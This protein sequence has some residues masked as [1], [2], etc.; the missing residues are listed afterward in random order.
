MKD[1]ERR[2]F[3][4]PPLLIQGYWFESVLLIAAGVMLLLGWQLKV[5]GLNLTQ[6]WLLGTMGG[7]GLLVLVGT[8]AHHQYQRHQQQRTLHDLQ[9]KWQTAYPDISLPP[10]PPDSGRALHTLLDQW[11]PTTKYP[12]CPPPK[13]DANSPISNLAE[14]LL[15]ESQDYLERI[16]AEK[17][18]SLDQM[19]AG[20]AH[21]INN[22]INFILGNLPLAQSYIQ[23][24]LILI[25]LYQQSLPYPG[26]RIEDHIDNIELDFIQADLPKLLASMQGGARR[27]QG[28]V[29]SLR[30]F[31]RLDEANLKAIDLHTGL[32][33][34]LVF[35]Q[36]RFRAVAGKNTSIVLTKNYAPLPLVECYASQLNQVFMILLTNALDAIDS[37][38]AIAPTDYQPHL[39]LHTQQVDAE[40]IQVTISDNGTGIAAD[41]G[42]R[43]FDPFFTTKPVGQGTG[44]GL[45]ISYQ[46]IVTQHHGRL[47]Y[48]S[49]PGEGSSFWVQI[50]ILQLLPHS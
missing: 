14:A 11:P 37:R 15:A 8:I 30:C 48:T 38:L 41:L 35:L 12:P 26:E 21:E 2:P 28:I 13:P 17:M 34:A 4:H 25:V 10:L 49:T 16:Q 43:L 33:S 1:L 47:N 27:I 32:D 42:D 20:L 7:V 19:V 46:V 29:E 36:H 18:A 31:S 40:T 39:T 45:A 9:Q 5:Q 3:P 22:P 24:L 44:L 23:D 50:P 6:C